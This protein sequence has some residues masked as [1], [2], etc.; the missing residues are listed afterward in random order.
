M[1]LSIEKLKSLLEGEKL[2]Y[3]LDPA[4]DKIMLG[5]KGMNGSYQLLILLE[6]E[7]T[8]IQFRSMNYHSCPADHEHVGATLKLLGELNY[9][10][11]FL[12][13]GWDPSDGEIVV[14]GD[15]W[16]EDGDLTQKQF[17]R[18]IHAYL[19]MMDL[20]NVRIDKTIRTGEDPGD[21]RP[22]EGGGAPSGLPTEMVELLRKLAEGVSG[23]G[24]DE[25]ADEGE[26]FL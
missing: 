2:K 19:T 7:N 1:A 12:K 13:F 15:A 14:Y 26:V 22:K 5:A 3:F 6:V 24:D 8:F 17:G 21:I 25:D 16:I 9:H 4:M 23:G 20:N 11:R 10:L 18:M